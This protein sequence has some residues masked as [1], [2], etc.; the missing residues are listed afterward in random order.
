MAGVTAKEIAA[1]LNLSPS[2]V[3]LALNGK[4]GVSEATR[5]LVVETA[6]RMGYSRQENNPSEP[7]R[8]VC[9]VRYAGAIVQ[10]AEHTSFSSF[11]LQG[12]ESRATE[13]GY[14]TQV[15]YLNAGD[16][17]NPQTLDFIRNADGVIFLGTDIT[18]TQ[19]PE[20]EQLF[21]SLGDTPVVVVDST[22]LA[23]RVDCVVNDCFGGARAAAELLL[24]TGH[25]RIG[26]VKAK[27][28]IRNLDER[29]RGVRAALAQADLPLSAVI[30]VDISSEG[31]FQDFDA[32]I[33]ANPDLPDGLFAE[34]DV[35]AAAVIRSLKK[36][37]YRVPH[38]VSVI[39]FDDIPMCEMLDPPLT[40]VHAFK[41]ELGII[42]VEHLDRRIKRG[43]V[44][45]QMPSIGLLTTTVS[46]R[47]VE[48]FSVKRQ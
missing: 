40:T 8:T 21:E 13:L 14:G 4:P 45:H 32:W 17:Y 23:N 22:V 41:E 30:E 31:A 36:H 3:S 46:T 47:L 19:L 18:E 11:V 9:F 24:R 34:N 12:V 42:A 20:L 35:L 26:Y 38:D 15:R 6:V 33:K 43:E 10:I 39:G 25:R 1:K 2:A 48:R 7:D 37:G 5:A 44:P 29:E 16:M 28:R 27:Q